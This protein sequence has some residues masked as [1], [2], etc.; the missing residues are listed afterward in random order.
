MPDLSPEEIQWRILFMV[1]A[2]AHA[3]ANPTFLSNTPLEKRESIAS[4]C[5]GTFLIDFVVAGMRAPASEPVRKEN[6]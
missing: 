2:M 4:D 1:G 5:V 6:S 3:M